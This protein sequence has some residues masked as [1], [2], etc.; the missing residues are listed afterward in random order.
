MAKKI[1]FYKA[2]LLALMGSLI[3]TVLG[4]FHTTKTAMAQ[5]SIKPVADAG[6]RKVPHSM[7]VRWDSDGDFLRDG[8]E[9]SLGLDPYDW[10]ENL[11]GIPDGREFAQKY[12][13]IIDALP[14][15]IVG[16]PTQTTV[17]KQNFLMFGLET[18]QVCGEI[19]NMGFTVI[20]NPMTGESIKVP[21]VAQHFM[22]CGS[23]QYGG[24]HNVGR[25]NAAKLAAVLDTQHGI[26]VQFDT[27]GDLMSDDEEDAIG[28]NP[29]VADQNGDFDLDGVDMAI[30]LKTKID[31]LPEVMHDDKVFKI[32]HDA[33]GYENCEI[34]G[35]AVNMGYLE[36]IDPLRNFVIEIPYIALHA[37]EHGSFSYDGTVHDGRVDL[38]G[39]REILTDA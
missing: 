17:V 5:D 7:P 32:R 11:N 39:L 20:Y 14:E 31:A 36:I 24:S 13:Q 2:L 26:P 4:F 1:K 25:I 22:E 12:V 16:D 21:F 34:C 33:R 9:T 3:A 28:S 6:V 29:Y 38:V 30:W 18:C 37:M 23:F 15:G 35:E 27:D 8:E 10:D 19:V